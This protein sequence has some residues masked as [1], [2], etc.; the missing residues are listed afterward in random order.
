MLQRNKVALPRIVAK[1][2][3][4]RLTVCL[5]AIILLVVLTKLT[6]ATDGMEP[7][8]TATAEAV[9]IMVADLVDA[10]SMAVVDPLDLVAAQQVQVVDLTDV[11]VVVDSE[12]LL[13]ALP[14]P[15]LLVV[16][17]V[18]LIGLTVDPQIAEVLPH[19]NCARV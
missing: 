12:V 14:D 8:I 4:L 16:I 15:D 6:V 5:L 1:S 10:V 19:P 3:M 18:D 11:M 9:D 7:V 13:M 17:L 2:I